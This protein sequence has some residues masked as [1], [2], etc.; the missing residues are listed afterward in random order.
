MYSLL[1]LNP[2]VYSSCLLSSQI[3]SFSY[4]YVLAN[5]SHL[6]DALVKF[7]ALQ[8]KFSTTA[9]DY[10]GMV[11]SLKAG[12]N[13]GR[14]VS[15]LLINFKDKIIPVKISDLALFG[16]DHK[17]TQLVTFSN[18]KYFVNQT[19]DEL[20]IICGVIFYRANR[21]Y[22]I[23]KEAIAEVQQYFARKLVVKL[24]IEGKYEIIISKIKAPEFLNWLKR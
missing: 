2:F 1:S 8:A 9:I 19:L 22:L 3:A 23:N 14:Q 4:K 12:M 16:I 20:E 15:C 17:T 18:Q 11:R 24:K 5:H 13:Q 7:N 21:Q 10:D 6:N